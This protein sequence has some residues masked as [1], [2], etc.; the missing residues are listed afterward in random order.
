MV[1]YG[2][3]EGIVPQACRGIFERLGAAMKVGRCRLKRV[4]DETSSSRVETAWFQRSQL[5]HDQLL[6]NC[7]DWGTNSPHTFPNG[8]NGQ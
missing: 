4:Q 1:G 7:N 5:R 6:S 8:T 2:A 3:D